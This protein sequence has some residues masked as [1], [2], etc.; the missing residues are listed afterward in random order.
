M[1]ESLRAIDW[2]IFTPTDTEDELVKLA[3]DYEGQEKDK[4]IVVA[5]LV[6]EDVPKEEESEAGPCAGLSQPKVYIRMNSTLVH[7]T[8]IFRE[9]LAGSS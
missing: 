8:T 6:F 2:D 3:E 4:I 5:G 1:E 7:D 9:R